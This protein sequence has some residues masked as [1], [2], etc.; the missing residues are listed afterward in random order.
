MFVYDPQ[1]LSVG[2]DASPFDAYNNGALQSYAPS[3]SFNMQ[4]LSN[5]VQLPIFWEVAFI[6]AIVLLIGSHKISIEGMIGAS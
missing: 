4:S 6:L 5:L 3:R 2:S 1:Q